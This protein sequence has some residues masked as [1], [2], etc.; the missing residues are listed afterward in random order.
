MADEHHSPFRF[1]VGASYF[2]SDGGARDIHSAGGDALIHAYG[3]HLLGEALWSLSN[4]ADVPTQPTIEVEQ[5]TSFA[6]VRRRAT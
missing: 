4:P 3:F 6:M 2:F 1:G 5:V